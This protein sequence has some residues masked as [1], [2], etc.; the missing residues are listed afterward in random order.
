[1]KVDFIEN[2]IYF[3]LKSEIEK[4][5]LEKLENLKQEIAK[6]EQEIVDVRANII[7]NDLRIRE[8]I[9]K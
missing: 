5:L 8:L 4:P 3:R 2:R 6:Q 9:N 7:R 1:M